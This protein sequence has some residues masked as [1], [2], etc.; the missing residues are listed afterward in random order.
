VLSQTAEEERKP[1]NLLTS[2]GTND[3]L[4]AHGK[5]EKTE[6]WPA[7]LSATEML[8]KDLVRG[9]HKAHFSPDYSSICPIK[10]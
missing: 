1:R 5:A 10:P 3:V 6:E 9:G 4:G 7:R 8:H 2:D